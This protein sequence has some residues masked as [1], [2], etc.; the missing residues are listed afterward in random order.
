MRLPTVLA[1]L[2]LL[3]LVSATRAQTPPSISVRHLMSDDEFRGA[4]LEK[5]TP[6]ELSRLDAWLARFGLTVLAQS[7]LAQPGPMS[8][9]G[10][11]E[12]VIQAAVNDETFIIND[13]VF[14]AKTYC[15]GVQQG[16]KV[17]FTAGSPSGVCVS[18]EFIVL[19]TGRTCR[20]WCE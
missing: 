11:R 12:Y 5:L 3:G 14:K 8:T 6:A 7:Q 17:I 16:D 20:C 15:F 19:R 9:G 18:A 10:K 4:G 13:A 1:T 2:L